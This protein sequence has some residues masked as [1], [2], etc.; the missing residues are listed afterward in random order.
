MLTEE[1]FSFT[2]LLLLSLFLPLRLNALS[3]DNNKI[4]YLA[5]GDSFPSGVSI[6][7]LPP[8]NK[9]FPAYSYADALY[10]MLKKKNTNLELK[11]FA[12]GGEPSD[13]L[14]INQL[15]NVTNFM[16]SN[17]GLT[18]LVTITTGINDFRNC[19]NSTNFSECFKSKLNNLT[20]NLNNMIIPRLKEAGGEGVQ[21][22]GTT[23][24][25]Y[26]SLDDSLVSIYSANG[27]KVVDFRR[28]ITNDTKCDYTYQ[29]KYGDIHPTPNGSQAIANV[30]F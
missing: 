7:G 26:P 15:N 8:G 17:S 24:F 29:C 14:I 4:Y 13:D 19:S 22:V 11:K 2:L 30:L 21:Y 3:D 28:I 23:Y 27:F 6:S 5:L 25:F 16:K 12:R 18:K 9:I 10:D 20:S 1:T